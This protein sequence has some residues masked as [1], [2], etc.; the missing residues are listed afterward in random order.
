MYPFKALP[1]Y[2][3]K[4]LTNSNT[5]VI[6]NPPLKLRSVIQPVHD[7]EFKLIPKFSKITHST[8][9]ACTI[10]LESEKCKLIVKSCP[11]SRH[12][13]KSPDTWGR[14]DTPEPAS[15]LSHVRLF[16]HIHSHGLELESFCY[17]CQVASIPAWVDVV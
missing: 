2:L 14:A 17:C 9:Q 10:E 15:N 13:L 16:R 11:R 12:R 1:N 6:K 3:Q 5:Q 7:H 4:W 8:S